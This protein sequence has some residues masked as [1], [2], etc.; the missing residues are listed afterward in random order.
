MREN[1][2]FRVVIVIWLGLL[3]GK[4]HREKNEHIKLH[5]G[6]GDRKEYKFLLCITM[7]TMHTDLTSYIWLNVELVLVGNGITAVLV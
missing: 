5:E 6:I 4:K 3:L 7:Y 2:K 1:V